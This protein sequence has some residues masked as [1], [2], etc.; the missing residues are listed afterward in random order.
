MVDKYDENVPANK[1]S[2]VRRSE[3]DR[4][5]SLR[6]LLNEEATGAIVVGIP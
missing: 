3:V 4:R 6:E 1:A 5:S 2:V